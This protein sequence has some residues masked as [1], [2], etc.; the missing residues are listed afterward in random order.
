MNSKKQIPKETASSEKLFKGTFIYTVGAFLRKGVNF[1]LLPLYTSALAASGYGALAMLT[2]FGGIV[3][4]SLNFG[5]GSAIT[6]KYKE[7]K[8]AGKEKVAENS[9]IS[10]LLVISSAGLLLLNLLCPLYANRLLKVDDSSFLV[11]LY[12]IAAV[13]Q[14]L[15]EV[16]YIFLRLRFRNARQLIINLINFVVSTTLI[17]IFVLVLKWG[18]I[19]VILG[20]L[21]PGVSTLVYF[22]LSWGYRPEFNKKFFKPLLRFGIWL[23][24]GNLGALIYTFSDRFFIQEYFTV[25]DVGI[26]SL[27]VKLS[28]MITFFLLKPFRQSFGPYVFQQGRDLQH[29]INLGLKFLLILS[30]IGFLG[31]SL[32]GK[33]IIRIMATREFLP[34]VSI[35]PILL[36][37]EIFNAFNQVLAVGIHKAGKSYIDS[38]IVWTAAA[39]NIGLNFLLIPRYKILGAALATLI[40]YIVMIGAYFYFSNKEIKY[41]I[42]YKFVILI[43][44]TVSICYFGGTYIINSAKS[45]PMK[46]IDYGFLMGCFL[47]VVY[48]LLS[49]TEK[50]KLKNLIRKKID[51]R[52]NNINDEA[53]LMVSNE[54]GSE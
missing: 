44:T 51:V 24:P 42:D 38:A 11:R 8:D 14:I 52:D 34:A 15:V 46:I 2:V 22:L 45:I 7:F 49:K 50:S 32:A 54:G 5:L 18:L 3:T 30:G 6:V 4:V 16:F 23:V 31:I 17:I 53:M 29:G 41:N 10:F 21:I 43:V 9:I 12:L 33:P 27:A 37:V 1:L 25:A 47:L 48:F 19:G 39:L 40:T 13:S 35:I 20:M 36:L 26:Y 28:G